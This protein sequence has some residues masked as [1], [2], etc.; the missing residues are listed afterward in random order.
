MGGLWK[1]VLWVGPVLLGATKM[2]LFR[3][4]LFCRENRT[5]SKRVLRGD[6]GWDPVIDLHSPADWVYCLSGQIRMSNS[7]KSSCFT[8][9]PSN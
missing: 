1:V 5:F 9:S 8:Q 3:P 7:V 6:S 2:G 4:Y